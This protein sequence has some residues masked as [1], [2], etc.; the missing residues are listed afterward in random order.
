[1]GSGGPKAMSR[2]GSTSFSHEQLCTGLPLFSPNFFPFPLVSISV[3]SPISLS[4]LT[5][6]VQAGSFQSHLF[7]PP[8]GSQVI[9]PGPS[10]GCSRGCFSQDGGCSLI[11]GFLP[12]PPQPQVVVLKNSPAV[13]CEQRSCLGAS[14]C[15]SFCQVIMNIWSTGGCRCYRL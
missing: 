9:P 14:S 4:F 1:M 5:C 10:N 15:S 11:F 3:A 7:L 2:L 8:E 6:P 13:D 12:F